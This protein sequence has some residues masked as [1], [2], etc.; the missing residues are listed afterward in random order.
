MNALLICLFF[1]VSLFCSTETVDCVKF[2]QDLQLILHQNAQAN[3]Q[4]SHDDSTLFRM[5]WYRQERNS[6]NLILISYSSS[7]TGE[8]SYE[9]GFTERFK[10]TRQNNLSGNLTISGLRLSDSAVYYCA[11]SKHS[12]LLKMTASL[13]TLKPTG[14]T[15]LILQFE[16]V[17]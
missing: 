10:L 12:A 1:I 8:P 11:A 17:I 4:C 13:K 16:V 15:V 2:K 3:I 6:T 9:T 14:S 7:S 5:L